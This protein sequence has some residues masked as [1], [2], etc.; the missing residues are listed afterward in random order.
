MLLIFDVTFPT[1]F[2]DASFSTNKEEHDSKINNLNKNGVEIE[3]AAGP[4]Q[5][6]LKIIDDRILCKQSRIDIV[7][8]KNK[9][10]ETGK[11]FLYLF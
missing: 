8:F 9:S 10:K 11:H 4:P 7:K 1:D 2:K 6:K 5:K 3:K